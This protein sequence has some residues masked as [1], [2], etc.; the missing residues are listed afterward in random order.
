MHP[1]QRFISYLQQNDNRG[2]AEIYRL[3]A[4]KIVRM[5]NHNNGSEADARDVLQEALIDIYRMSADGKFMLTC[6]F[7]AFLVTICK[8]KWLNVLK[9]RTITPV[10]KS[11][12][13][14]FTIERSDEVEVNTHADQLERENVVME[15][16]ETMGMKC[17][18]IIKACMGKVHQEQVADQLG[19]TYA[20]LRKKKS[21]C[22]AQLGKLVK[23]HPLFNPEQ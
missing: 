10:T 6:P 8:R 7:E 18:D 14:G 12:D 1:D 22:M 15:V 5:I 11:L 21:E 13:D 20:Y 9:K 2:I 17:R 4:N 19:L 16:L 23:A 3:Y